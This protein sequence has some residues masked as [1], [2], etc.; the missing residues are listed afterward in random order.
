MTQPLRGT[1]GASGLR[2]AQP[3]PERRPHKMGRL[4]EPDRLWA[5]DLHHCY[6]E[7]WPFCG[8]LCTSR[9]SRPSPGRL[10]FICGCGL[11]VGGT[12]QGLCAP[13]GQ[14]RTVFTHGGTRDGV[15]HVAAE[16]RVHAARPCVGAAG[17]CRPGFSPGS[18]AWGSPGSPTL[19]G[20]APAPRGGKELMADPVLT[21][22]PGKGP[23]WGASP[24]Q[25]GVGGGAASLAQA[26]WSRPPAPAGQLCGA[27][28]VRSKQG[29]GVDVGFITGTWQRRAS[30][31]PQRWRGP[32]PE[33]GG[34]GV[35]RSPSPPPRLS[36]GPCSL[37]LRTVGRGHAPAGLRSRTAGG[38]GLAFWPLPPTAS[39]CAAVASLDGGWGGRGQRPL[40]VTHPV[41]EVTKSPCRAG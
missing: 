18:A 2:P 34:G 11:R 39:R 5:H 14:A 37:P 1:G 3:I 20:F 13:A 40:P 7:P 33:P 10:A 19:Q 9:L 12:S 38:N 16:E 35:R 6:P 32:G 24:P 25:E 36:P 29:D 21:P 27:G 41:L 30:L 15:G 8:C 23:E 17:P 26:P 22:F 4:R 28:S 31:S